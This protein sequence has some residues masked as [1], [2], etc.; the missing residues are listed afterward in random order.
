M[1]GLILTRERGQSIRIGD[2]IIITL[3]DMDRGRARIQIDAPRNI[4]VH[5]EEVYRRIHRTED[6]NGNVAEPVEE[7]HDE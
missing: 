4:P 6:G 5:R 1:S 3:V 7:V 2:D